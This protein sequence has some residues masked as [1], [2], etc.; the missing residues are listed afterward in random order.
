MAMGPENAQT[1]PAARGDMELLDEHIQMLEEYPMM[2]ETY[3]L[4]SQQ[5]IDRSE[6]D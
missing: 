6:S 2:K 4:I 1:G 3:Q 5:I